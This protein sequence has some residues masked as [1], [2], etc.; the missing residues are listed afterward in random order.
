M[1]DFENLRLMIVNFGELISTVDLLYF[2]CGIEKLKVPNDRVILNYLTIQMKP[3][4]QYFLK[5]T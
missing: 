1:T 5:N 2:L 4:I 3:N